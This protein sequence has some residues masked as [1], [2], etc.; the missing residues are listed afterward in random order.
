MVLERAGFYTSSR[1]GYSSL[2]LI[3]PP[4]KSDIVLALFPF[5]QSTSLDNKEREDRKQNPCEKDKKVVFIHMSRLG[6]MCSEHRQRPKCRGLIF[7]SWR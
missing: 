2:L 4:L 6:E 1:K 7:Q 5:K 3:L